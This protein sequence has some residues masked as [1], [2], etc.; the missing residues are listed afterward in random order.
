[1]NIVR[2]ISQGSL[3]LVILSCVFIFKSNVEAWCPFGGVEALYGYFYLGEMPCSLAASN[4][5]ILFT[6]LLLTIILGRVFCSYLC[7]L[8]AISTFLRDIGK[9]LKLPRINVPNKIEIILTK[10]KYV[11]LGLIIYLTWTSGELIFREADPC[12]ALISRHGEDITIFSYLFLGIIVFGSLFL[13]SIFCRYLCPFAAVMNIFSRL[14][15]VKINLDKEKCIGCGKCE[16]ACPMQLKILD[17]NKIND[18]NCINCSECV[19]ACPIT[20]KALTQKSHSKLFN[21][22]SI[23]KKSIALIVVISIVLFIGCKTALDNPLPSYQ[24]KNTKVFKTS[25]PEEKFLKSINL[26]VKGVK[27]RGSAK[28]FEFYLYRDDIDKLEGYIHLQVWTNPQTSK[29]KIY[30]DSRTISTEQILT[31]LTEAYYDED[32]DRWRNPTFE[33]LKQL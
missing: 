33:I 14:K 19:I 22:L 13:P 17:K 16:K 18:V 9:K 10:F 6:I 21:R 28:L 32:D 15:L 11:T 8:G 31:A 24:S 5:Y 25:K 27:C 26:M 29:A 1:M 3:L 20:D 7:P 30:Y 4:L 23:A 2:R 12:Y